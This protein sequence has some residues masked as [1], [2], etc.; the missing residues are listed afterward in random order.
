MTLLKQ[1][2]KEDI[3]FEKLTESEQFDV[4]YGGYM[5]LVEG[6]VLQVLDSISI[7]GKWD[8]RN[9][10]IITLKGKRKKLREMKQWLSDKR[11]DVWLDIYT[12]YYGYKKISIKKNFHKVRGKS[13]TTVNKLIKEYKQRGTKR[14]TTIRNRRQKRRVQV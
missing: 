5:R 14:K 9:L 3:E 13:V 12:D 2:K 10:S 4:I 7:S 8:D 11:W 6:I 1:S